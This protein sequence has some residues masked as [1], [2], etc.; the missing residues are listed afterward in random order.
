M[1]MSPETMERQIE[2]MR[3]TLE[4]GDPEIAETN[5]RAV[6]AETSD[7]DMVDFMDYLAETLG[8]SD[9]SVMLG[10]RVLSLVPEDRADRILNLGINRT[11]ERIVQ[12]LNESGGNVSD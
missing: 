3:A 1:E 11:G 6:F 5:L 2:L 12:S 4:T 9:E 10:I 7:N 8:Y